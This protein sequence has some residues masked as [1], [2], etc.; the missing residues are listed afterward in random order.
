MVTV[1]TIEPG[2]IA[3]NDP[4]LAQASSS[5]GQMLGREYGDA[6]RAA[7]REEAEI[8]RNAEAIAAVRNQ[9]T[10]AGEF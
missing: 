8:E 5:L 4:L 3:A 10:G 1:D 2:R 6:L 7:I 9:L